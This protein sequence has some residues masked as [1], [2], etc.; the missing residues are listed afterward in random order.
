MNIYSKSFYG[1]HHSWAVVMRSIMTSFLK[2]KHSISIKSINGYEN[3]N[4]ELK[5]FIDNFS[6]NIDLEICYTMPINFPNRF[7]EKSKV[8]M[9]IYNYE[10]SSNN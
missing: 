5:P 4:D 1:T 3:I 7:K 9:A 2:K 10:S 8:K 6:P